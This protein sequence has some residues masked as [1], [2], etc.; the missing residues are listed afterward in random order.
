M[1][2][3][4]EELKNWIGREVDYPAPEAFGRAAFRYFAMAVE[5]DNPL[6]RDDEFARSHGYP[7]AIAPPTFAVETCQYADRRPDG[8]GYIGHS[9]HLPIEGCRMIR[10]GNDYTFERAV[11]PEDRLSVTWTLENIEERRRGSGGTQLFVSSVA[12][13][14]DVDGSLVA[15]NVETLVYQPL[16]D[17]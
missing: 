4:T 10:A 16:S 1:A 17:G 7:S 14:Y 15:E 12:R 8:H 9:W 6:Y 13:Y 5:D 3:L 11:L 2:L